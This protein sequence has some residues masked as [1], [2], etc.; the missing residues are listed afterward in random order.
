MCD[1]HKHGRKIIL[2]IEIIFCCLAIIITIFSFFIKSNINKSEELKIR[3]N[4]ETI[5]NKKICY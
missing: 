2:I 4:F 1:F 3:V 5:T